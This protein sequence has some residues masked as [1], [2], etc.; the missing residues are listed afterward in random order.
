MRA[1]DFGIDV[2]HHNTVDDWHAVRGNN[3]TFAS[4]K[5]TDGEEF[6]DPQARHH[7]PAARAAGIRVGGYHF[8]RTGNVQTQ[9]DSFFK[10]LHARAMLSSTSLAPMLDMEEASGLRS[11][12]NTFIPQFIEK[13]RAK[14]GLMR[15][16]VY[17][18][19]D[20][21]QNVLR[22]N[23]WADANVMLWIARFNGNPGKPGFSH[24]NLVLHQHTESGKVP[25]IPGH[26]D[27]DAT[28]GS[29]KLADLL[30]SATAP[31]PA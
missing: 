10:Q 23:E 7:G 28:I 12:A 21:F 2:S 4:I 29:H 14:A 15:V 20:W 8:A 26:V 19:L 22:P 25:G 18:N 30:L 17:A 6:V 3:I 24:P 9:V 31:A 1:M 27:R 5:V 16:F 11:T 13:F